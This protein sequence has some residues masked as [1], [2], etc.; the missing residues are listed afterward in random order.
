LTIHLFN[1][2]ARVF[3]QEVEQGNTPNLKIGL[4][5]AVISAAAPHS[6]SRLLIASADIAAK[7]DNRL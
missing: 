2:S 5:Q 6:G 1:W 7:P 3:D 4:S